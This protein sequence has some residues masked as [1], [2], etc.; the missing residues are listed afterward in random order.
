MI[1]GP[2][3]QFAKK[4]PKC[5]DLTQDCAIKLFFRK[6]FPRVNIRQGLKV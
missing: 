6:A 2:K 1:S 3:H 5:D 4:I